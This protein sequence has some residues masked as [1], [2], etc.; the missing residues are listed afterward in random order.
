MVHRN[1]TED[2]PV[3]RSEDY[4]SPAERYAR[5]TRNMAAITLFIALITGIALIGISVLLLGDVSGIQCAVQ[6]SC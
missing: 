5:Q 3:F 2:I 1:S 6:V 4:E